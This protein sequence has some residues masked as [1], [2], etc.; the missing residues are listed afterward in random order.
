MHIKNELNVNILSWKHL[1]YDVKYLKYIW[2]ALHSLNSLKDT[3]FTHVNIICT[4]LFNTDLAMHNVSSS[5]HLRC[6]QLCLYCHI[7]AHSWAQQSRRP[8]ILNNTFINTS[9]LFI[10]IT[11]LIKSCESLEFHN[12]LCICMFRHQIGG[13]TL[14]HITISLQIKLKVS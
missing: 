12:R 10:S 14:I 11:G 7:A 3:K 5:S 13:R 4:Y 6:V 9:K 1:S 8:I 2:S